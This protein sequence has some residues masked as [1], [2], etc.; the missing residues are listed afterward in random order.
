MRATWRVGWLTPIAV[1]Y[2]RTGRVTY[3][4][5]TN[6]A[7]LRDGFPG[8]H[9]FLTQGGDE[10][11]LLRRLRAWGTVLWDSDNVVTTSSRRLDQGLACTLLVSYGYY[12]ATSM[13]L[14]RLSSR[15]VIGVAPVIRRGDHDRVKRRRRRWRVMSTAVLSAALVYRL[16]RRTTPFAL[17]RGLVERLVRRTPGC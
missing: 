3:L 9:V 13:F 15:Q 2:E 8:Y 17:V 4:T 5:A 16:H 1:A 14:G 12:Y 6:V 7:Y 10:T 11:D